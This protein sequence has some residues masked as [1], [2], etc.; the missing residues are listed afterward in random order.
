MATCSPVGYIPCSTMWC[1]PEECMRYEE[2]ARYEENLLYAE[3]YANYCYN[4]SPD[5]DLDFDDYDDLIYG[6]KYACCDQDLDSNFDL[7]NSVEDQ[8]C[9]LNDIWMTS[10]QEGTFLFSANKCGIKAREDYVADQQR[11][12]RQD[13]MRK[14]KQ[15]KKSTIL[16]HHKQSTNKKKSK[17]EHNLQY[18]IDF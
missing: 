18:L 17:K 16:Y 5:F 9:F 6:E 4:Y 13:R 2:Y 10:R 1:L 12:V 15:K 14:L 7:D 11:K 8:E 3:E